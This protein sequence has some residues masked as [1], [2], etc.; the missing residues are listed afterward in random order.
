MAD[1]ADGKN[2]DGKNEGG[3]MRKVFH[4]ESKT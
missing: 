1:E 4:S 2:A 3:R